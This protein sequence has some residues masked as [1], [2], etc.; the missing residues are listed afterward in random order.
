MEELLPGRK[1]IG[2]NSRWGNKRNSCSATGDYEVVELAFFLLGGGVMW[3]L[4][5]STACATVLCVFYEHAGASLTQTQ[6]SMV[7]V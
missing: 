3:R 2:F 5:D 7:K 6:A 1:Y 4:A